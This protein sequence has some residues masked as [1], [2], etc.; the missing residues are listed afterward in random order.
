MSIPSIPT[1]SP[2]TRVDVVADSC[3]S[4]NK[5]P[6]NRAKPGRACNS[7]G[8]PNP[9]EARF[10]FNCGTPQDVTCSVCGASVLPGGKFCSQCG[11]ALS[12]NDATLLRQPTPAFNIRSQL[13]TALVQKT[14]TAAVGRKGERRDVTVLFLD[15]VN[16]T[17]TSNTLDSEDVYLFVNDA[18][19]LLADV[20]QKYEGTIDKFTGD[21]L[22]ALFGAPIAHEDDPVRAV[23]A[24]LEMQTILT[25]LQIQ[26]REKY[27]FDLKVRIGIN[28]GLAI[29]GK[30]GS[31]SHMEYTVIGDTVNLASRLESV[32]QPGTVLVSAETYQRTRPLFDYE[33]LPPFE[34]KGYS[35][36]ITAFR[37]LGLRKVPQSLRG[38]AGLQAPMI[39]RATELLQLQVAFTAV[40][41]GQARLGLITGDA[42]VGKSR[43]V[44]EF[45]QTLAE[46][47]TRVIQGG[48]Q[49]YT[50]ATPLW[51]VTE[52]VR[53]M[54]GLQESDSKDVQCKTLH[55]YLSRQKLA[56]NETAPYLRQI[57]GCEQPDPVFMARFESMDAAMLQKQTHS[58]LRQLF[59]SES[60]QSTTVF[61]FEDLHWIDP[62]S[63]EFLEYFIQTTVDEPLLLLLVSRQLERETTLQSLVAAAGQEPERLVDLQLQALSTTEGQLLVDQLIGQFTPEAQKLKQ[64]IIKRAEGI[65]FYIE[66]IIRMLIDQGGITSAHKMWQFG[67]TA[68]QIIEAV[69]G[70]LK[71]LILAR[72]DQL[73]EGLRQTLQ[74]AAVLGN[75]FPVKLLLS[76]MNIN[77]QTVAVHFRELERR[78]FIIS[79]PI[80]GEAAYVFRHALLQ[81]TI[82]GTLLKQDRQRIHTQAA[83]E[84]EKDHTWHPDDR[85]EALAYHYVESTTPIRAIPYLIT[86]AT[87]AARRCA[88]ETAVKNYRQ[89]IDLLPDKPNEHEQQFFQVRLGL[90]TALKFLG[91]FEEAGQTLTEALNYLWDSSLSDSS[92]SLWPILVESLQQMAD[93]RQR[94]GVYDA[95]L[96]YLEAGLQVLG[97]EGA[98]KQSYLWRALLDRLAWVRFRQGRLDEAF[99]LARSAVD[100]AREDNIIEPVK[101][102]SLYNTLGGVCWQLGDLNQA[103]AFV[104]NSMSLYKD[105]GYTWGVAI[106]HG[107]LGILFDVQGYW[108]KAIERYE[109]AYEL[110][111]ITGDLQNQA[112][113]LDNL[114]TLYM[115]MGQHDKAKRD[116]ETGLAIRRRVGDAWGTAQSQVNLASLAL[117][118]H[119][120]PE[121]IEYAG[122]AL[123][124]ADDIGSLELQIQAR[125]LLAIALTK[126]KNDLGP[127]LKLAEQA[128]EMARAN[129]LSEKETEC[130][131]ALGLIH[132]HAKDF[133]AAGALLRQSVALAQT[134]DDPYRQ[135]LALLELA[136]LAPGTG[137][138]SNQPDPD[139]SQV[140]KLAELEEAIGLFQTLGATYYLTEAQNLHYQIQSEN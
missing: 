82:Y 16:F 13:P 38:L 105:I 59:L 49:A 10:C 50:S 76:L 40:R 104:E 35:E 17:A 94:E 114:G 22:M 47:N 115:T 54:I 63:K 134:Q 138:Q 101:L 21:G 129:G 77:P 130:L 111:Q 7:C 32:A 19:S 33:T 1:N 14:V 83:D 100:N 137:T 28:T 9:K 110:H 122:P 62:A 30:L 58:A 85:A 43:L 68:S 67:P 6:T 12:K 125:W 88:N 73:P 29:A 135:G 113:N 78:Q 119:I 65:P 26:L 20:I 34:V 95:A 84:I 123:E 45:Q 52:I 61:I 66:E 15:I 64:K 69:P 4:L 79:R 36:A 128:L 96:S 136:R 140:Q 75:A 126:T 98:R 48:C 120:W 46:S 5:I 8:Q 2:A 11:T 133:T 18:M 121:V 72:F 139:I 106:A 90:G 127:G 80:R 91:R 31:N 117:T 37:P 107:N 23:R 87:N 81:E 56:N 89:V 53:Q 51:L 108:P 3:G 86:T 124:I 41:Q 131:F 42:G 112:S 93:I 44:R 97:E 132:G 74:N 24:G 116:L 57:L 25:P 70:T 118:R 27:G 103:V 109:Q 99:N 60:R 71:G 92:A 102:A 55:S 39:G